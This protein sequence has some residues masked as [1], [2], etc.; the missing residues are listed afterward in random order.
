MFGSRSSKISKPIQ[1]PEVLKLKATSMKEPLSYH[2][3]GVLVHAGIS[4]NA[5]HYYSFVRASND[6]WYQMDDSRV[7]QVR[8][9][10]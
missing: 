2:L 7:S 5:G 8:M 3:R 6:L 1:F 4:V 10:T 9:F